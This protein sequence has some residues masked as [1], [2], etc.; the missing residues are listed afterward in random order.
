[1]V[2]SPCLDKKP[3]FFIELQQIFDLFGIRS[4]KIYQDATKFTSQ[5][6]VC[7]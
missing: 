1:M 6:F 2:K 5:I 4:L 7:Q 3:N